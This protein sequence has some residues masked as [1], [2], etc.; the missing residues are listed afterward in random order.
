M[1]A[2]NGVKV[3][4]IRAQGNIGGAVGRFTA[5][6]S[7]QFARQGHTATLLPNG[8]VLVTGGMNATGTLATAELFHPPSGTFTR[9]GNMVTARVG[10]TA[11]LLADGNVLVTGGNALASAELYKSR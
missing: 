8:S 7:M 3:T 9:T 1:S 11:T 10:H 6:S 5:T 2:A 4:R